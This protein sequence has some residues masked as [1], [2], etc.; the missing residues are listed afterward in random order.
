[1][2][3]TRRSTL[4]RGFLSLF[5]LYGFVIS[6]VA[7]P[8]PR[9]AI[10]SPVGKVN[11]GNSRPGP[12]AATPVQGSQHRSG[13]LLVRFRSGLAQQNKDTVMAAHGARRKRLLRGESTVEQLEVL[14]GQNVETVALQMSLNPDVE[15]AE[16]NFLIRKDQ[17]VTS[18]PQFADQ[19]ALRN[20]G[21]GAGQ[22]GS[23]INVAAAWNT[24]TGS[25]STVIA[26]V[27]SGIDFTHPDLSDNEW[28]NVTHGPEGDAHGWDYITDSGVIKDEQGHGTAIAG[29]IAAEG[30]N[31]V[32]I[33]GVMWRA[34]LMSLRVLDNTGT[35]D[36]GDAVEAIDYAVNNGAQVINLSWGT[37]GNSQ[38][39]KDAI[40]RAMRRGVV[41]VCSAGNNGQDV[42]TSPYYPASFGLRDLIA[43]ASTDN[44]DQLITWSDYGRRNV[45][46]AAPGNNILTTRMGGGYWTVNGTSASAP[47]VSGVAGLLKSVRPNAN[48]QSVARAISDGARNVVSL[49]GKVS[50][51]GVVDASATLRALRGNPYGGGG[52]D[53]GGGN[54][55]GNGQG[56]VPTGQRQDNPG[57]ANG[58]DGRD[59]TPPPVVTGA[60][61]PN[62]PNLNQLRNVRSSSSQPNQPI[63]ANFPC[64]DC[65]P[66]SGGG[67]SQY[68]PPGDPNFSTAR[69]LPQNETGA[70]GVDLRSRNFNWSQP[71]LSLAGRSGMDLNL[72]L[73]YN[74]LVW[75]KDGLNI[76]YNA[77]LGAPAPGFRLGLPTLQQKFNQSQAG[78]LAY[79][80]VMPSGARIEMREVGVG[81]Y[82][83]ADGTYTQLKENSTYYSMVA[84]HSG[85][86]AAVTETSMVNGAQ[87]VQ[88]PNPG[89][90]DTNFEWQLVPTDSGYYKLVNHHSGKV[91]AMAGVSQANGASVVQWDWAEG[92]T[93]EQWQIVSLGIGYHKLIARHSGKVLSIA[94]GSSSQGAYL[95]QWTG[96]PALYQQWQ[97]VPVSP[98]ITVRTTDGTQYTFTKV[99]VNNEY[100]CT[101]IKDRNGNYLT[102]TY[103]LNNGH[104]Q[105]IKDT[106]DRLIT[107]D[108]YPDG[109]LQAIRQTWATGDHNWATFNYGQVTVNPQFGGGLSVN[110]PSNSLVTVITRVNL[111]DGSSYRFEYNAPFGQVNGINHYAADDHL[112]AYTKYNMD[113]SIGQTDCPR[114]TERRSWAQ[115]WNGDVEGTPNATEEALTA[116]STASDDSWTKVIFPDLTIYKEY[117]ATSGWEKGMTTSAKNYLNAGDEAADLPR[118]RIDIIWTQDDEDLTYPKNIRVRETNIHDAEGNHKRVTTNYGSYAPYGLPYE[119]TEFAADATTVL[120]KRFT[121]YN[122]SSAYVDRRIIG[123]VSAVQVT[124]GSGNFFSKTTFDYDWTG[125]YLTATPQTAT[126]HDFTNYGAGFVTGRGNLSAVSRWDVTDI[127]NAA[128]VIQQ[129]RI[130]YN[131]AGSVT[132]TRD[133]LGHQSSASY[134]DS[135]SVAS[136]N[137]SKFAYPTTITDAE[138]FQSLTKYNFD[139]GAV[140]FKQT[141]APNGGTP[142]SAS[143]TYDLKGR[144]TRVTNDLNTASTEWVYPDTMTEIN[145]FTT[146]DPGSISNAS[147]RAFSTTLLDGAGRVRLTASE[148]P[149]TALRYSAQRIIYDSMGRVF[150]QSN[151]TEVNDRWLPS[152]DDADFVDTQQA[153]DWKGRPT[154]TTNPDGTTRVASYG[155]CGCAGGE[156]TT[157]QDEHGR[158]RR[159]TK[160][161]FGRLWKVEELNWNATVYA[162]TTYSYNVRDQLIESNQA[163]QLRSFA[164]DGYGRLS[165]RTTPEQGT[166]SYNYNLDDTTNF[167]T[168]ARG[169]KTTF[170]YNNPRHLVSSITYDLSNL[171]PG[172]SVAA[173]PNVSSITYD[174]AGNRR[175]MTDGMGGVT[176]NYNNLSQLTSE[177]RTFT[178]VSGSYSLSY[179]YNLANE[180]T[181]M[182]NQ[183][184]ATIN[185]E[186]DKIGRVN[187]VTTPER[188]GPTYASG[189]SYRAFGAIKGMNYGD[190]KSLSALYD[191][192]LRP[193]KWDVSTVLGYNYTY[194]NTYMNETTGR[195]SYAQNIY[196][197]TL[198]RSYEYDHVGRLIVSHSGTE[199]RAHAFDGNLWGTMDGP[200]S[201][202]YDFDVWGNVIHKSGWGGEVQGGTAGQSSDK[203]YT[204]TGN[205][206]NGFS[207]DA[208]GNLTNDLG[209]TFTYDATGQQTTAAYGGYSLQQSYDGNGLRAKKSDNGAVTYYLRSSV[210]GG[211]V[212]AEMSGSGVFQRS[213]I[214]LG[215]QVLALKLANGSSYW[216]H[217][218]PIT[219]SKRITDMFGAIISTIELDPWGADTNRST[220]G[221]FQ[222]KKFTSYERDGNGSDEAMFRHSNRWHS[223][224]DQPDP[225]NG[226]YDLANPQSLNRYAYVQGDPVN[227]IDPSGL[228]T[229]EQGNYSAECDASGFGGWGGGWNFNDRGH[230]GQRDID[231]GNLRIDGWRNSV[232]YG[233]GYWSGA[234]AVI[235]L[236]DGFCWDAGGVSYVN[237]VLPSDFNF[238]AGTRNLWRGPNYGWPEPRNVGPPKVTSDGQPIKTEPTTGRPGVRVDPNDVKAPKLDP[239]NPTMPDNP[240]RGQRIRFYMGGVAQLIKAIFGV[241]NVSAVPPI[242]FDAFQNLMCTANPNGAGCRGPLPQL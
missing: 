175:T 157:V 46:V 90:G 94:T 92:A 52:G 205:R 42:D 16:P 4:L 9:H 84:R 209:Q 80:M 130:G 217:E 17:V 98:N 162:T 160:D 210:L 226:S 72:S 48:P 108:Y 25:Q 186:Y 114:F 213:Y 158:Q 121:D 227:L 241:P 43:V 161:T 123:L 233:N 180:L 195:V 56:Y 103:D 81:V 151:P 139:F 73:S 174:P 21:Q 11:P 113:G 190:G 125:E 36:I 51:G 147:L 58:R 230:P 107:F 44:F 95:Q 57:R 49:A 30:N 128:K 166:T 19:W 85:L 221:A 1:M 54:G 127:N 214:Y 148:L 61:A 193:T 171:V 228:M 225:Y 220:N 141:P 8:L 78:T 216:V 146:I 13:E 184:G 131:S 77:D 97:F 232:W 23:D 192:R 237:G 170:V 32:G 173:T 89:T 140:T 117:F 99:T 155:G 165:S 154:V 96:T 185:Y 75:T 198:D 59:E 138:G 200:Y 63:Q 150:K 39:L 119:V 104:L 40:E 242:S 38:I 240:T 69:E 53:Q 102:A 196:D 199:A 168:D 172:Q 27:D 197:A 204:Y 50:S 234:S 239:A 136:N 101:E 26:V 22:F 236:A 10:A 163:T 76:K 129:R 142:P 159:L 177:I 74:S 20:I 203:Y 6:L 45:S 111:D 112:L 15:F 176:Y 201:Q 100:R 218:D 118:K 145:Q 7:L 24:T 79:M 14:G 68:Y 135:F 211:Q 67:G 152:G 33:T 110:G 156:V 223:R 66:Q 60:P 231:I 182:T 87:I 215:G 47:L 178:G 222:P 206:R 194:N 149:P 181:S 88:W 169:A 153:Y 105:T 124:D 82:E 34:S 62:L 3:T 64:A 31:A 71:L 12:L 116:Y 238:A 86:S 144:L 208:A 188:G 29:I 41:V 179:A 122:L 143:S 5:L 120:R 219:K 132:L 164:Y 93:H 37:T 70:P 35:G 229:C 126:Q 202:G 167:V 55:N 207:Y 18:D 235:C 183:W 137:G 106:L 212:V 65:D 28:T 109:N 115:N 133:A 83:S 91:A 224:F 134:V 187:G 189:L 2:Q 191:S